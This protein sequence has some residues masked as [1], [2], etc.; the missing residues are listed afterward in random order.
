MGGMP[1]A[2]E[3]DKEAARYDDGGGGDGGDNDD[4]GVYWLHYFLCH[5]HPSEKSAE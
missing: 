3:L 2:V 4:D 5:Q 1:V